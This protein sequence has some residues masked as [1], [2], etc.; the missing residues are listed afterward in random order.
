MRRLGGMILRRVTF[1]CIDLGG[2]IS[3]IGDREESCR[4]ESGIRAKGWSSSS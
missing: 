2:E 4:G 1:I 3:C